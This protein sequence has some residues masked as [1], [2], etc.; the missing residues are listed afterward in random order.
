MY[1]RPMD[2]KQWMN[3]WCVINV[4]PS[5]HIF[6]N[7]IY[8]CI[9][10]LIEIYRIGNQPPGVGPRPPDRTVY[11]LVRTRYTRH[12]FRMLKLCILGRATCTSKWPV[13]DL[14][15]STS[16]SNRNCELCITLLV[17]FDKQH[18]R[19]DCTRQ[20]ATKATSDKASVDKARVNIQKAKESKSSTFNSSCYFPWRALWQ[21]FTWLE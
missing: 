2:V 7:I 15:V 4:F 6:S 19:H 3:G 12:S 17:W 13:S 18:K 10:Y 14:G 20:D 21:V 9:F 8:N 11:P 5:T 1:Y 16:A